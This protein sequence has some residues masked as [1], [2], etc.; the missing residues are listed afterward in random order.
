MVKSYNIFVFISCINL[1]CCKGLKPSKHVLLKTKQ[2]TMEQFDIQKFEQYKINNSATYNL[3]DGSIVQLTDLGESYREERKILNSP[4]STGFIFYKNATLTLKGGG[5]F[6]YNNPT[7]IFNEY[8]ESGNL[9][10]QINYDGLYNFTIQ[11]LIDLLNDN[12]QIDLTV[13]VKNLIVKRYIESNTNTP[14]YHIMYP[15]DDQ[16]FRN[17]KINGNTGEIILDAIGHYIE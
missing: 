10:N 2:T 4:F 11:N 6:F 12:Y 16:S 9:V 3:E 7:G 14:E 13:P 1:L 5:T 17:L 15:I 8:D